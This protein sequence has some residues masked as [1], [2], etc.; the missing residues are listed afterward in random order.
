METLKGMFL[1]RHLKGRSSKSLERSWTSY[2]GEG[3]DFAEILE[4]LQEISSHLWLPVALIRPNDRFGVELKRPGLF[5]FGLDAL[6]EAAVE[7]AERLDLD[8]EIEELDT[9]DDYVRAFA[10]KPQP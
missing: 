3:Y 5:T 9:V 1:P 7:R 4:L 2:E 8:V 10:N 6:Y